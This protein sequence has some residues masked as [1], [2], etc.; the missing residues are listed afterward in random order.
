MGDFQ[1]SSLEALIT[2]V[3]TSCSAS[4]DLGDSLMD[5]R[6]LPMAERFAFRVSG[7]HARLT[8]RPM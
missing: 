4:C 6:E 3:M 7:L 8:E 1:I 2:D 5:G